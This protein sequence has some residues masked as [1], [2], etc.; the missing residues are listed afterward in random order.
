MMP[1]PQ[2]GPPMGGSPAGPGGGSPGGGQGG[3]PSPEEVRQM[4][5]QIIGEARKLAQQYGIDFNSLVASPEQ[6]AGSV[7]PPPR[8]PMPAM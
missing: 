1:S 3:Q 6:S 4:L 8:S 5:T 2:A 7:P